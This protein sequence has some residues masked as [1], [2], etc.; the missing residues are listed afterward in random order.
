MR[1]LALALVWTGCTGTFTPVL[2][3][4][5]VPS[6]SGS[7]DSA[8]DSGSTDSGPGDSGA[9]DSGMTDS[10]AAMA[11]DSFEHDG[12]TATVFCEDLSAE[13]PR[14][15]RPLAVALARDLVERSRGRVETGTGSDGRGTRVGL[16]F[17]GTRSGR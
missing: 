8:A 5:D 6:D 9:G 10:G 2:P 17:S 4:D 15:G 3:D 16:L 12:S 14:R 11:V 7:V 13:A 1:W